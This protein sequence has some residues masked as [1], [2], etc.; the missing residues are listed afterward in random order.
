M[1]TVGKEKENTR[2]SQGCPAIPRFSPIQ[3]PKRHRINR[4][5]L[6]QITQV[7]VMM[8]LGHLAKGASLDE[9]IEACIESFG[10][11]FL[12]KY[13]GLS[14]RA[15]SCPRCKRASTAAV[16][17]KK[18]H[19]IRRLPGTH[20]PSRL[21]RWEAT[22]GGLCIVD[23]QQGVLGKVMEEG[24]GHRGRGT[25][26]RGPLQPIFLHPGLKSYTD[27]AGHILLEGQGGMLD[28]QAT[29]T[30]CMFILLQDICIAG[31]DLPDMG[32]VFCISCAPNTACTVLKH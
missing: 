17:P 13:R 28:A 15:P 21:W 30:E 16:V 8:S 27:A 23:V 10:S 5:S 11:H 18:V 1:G 6:A 22:T 31:R 2:L 26:L 25:R 12:L 29:C 3:R 7:K 4:P 24:S 19:N 9:L 20:H 14:W 32:L